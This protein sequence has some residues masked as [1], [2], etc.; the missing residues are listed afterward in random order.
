[1]VDDSPVVRLQLSRL[2]RRD[3]QIQIVGKALD[4]FAARDEIFQLRPDVVLLDIGLPR[5]D[6][7]TFLKAIM[8]HQPMPVIIVSGLVKP[9]SERAIAALEAGAFDVVYKTDSDE[10]L[11]GIGQELLGKIHQ[12]AKFSTAR[13]PAAIVHTTAPRKARAE[14]TLETPRL[15]APV[16][17]LPDIAT[18]FHP[19]Q[20]LLLGASTGGTEALKRILTRLP[21]EMP[22]IAIVQHIPPKFSKSFADRLNTICAL[23]VREAVDGDQLTPGLALIAPGGY[24]MEIFWRGRNYEVRLNQRPEV[25]HQRPAVDLLFN[26]AAQCAGPHAVA[27]LLTGMGRDGAE[28]LKRLRDAG[29]QTVAQD[30]ASC[31]VFGMPMA[32][33]QLGAAE[34][35]ISLDAMPQALLRRLERPPAKVAAA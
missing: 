22:P 7:I 13:G 8:E 35:M 23:E 16:R 21:S 12:A 26:S 14:P 25:H 24:H 9:G 6:G 34:Q 19:R 15:A 30:E 11:A 1:M 5:L 31:V 32:A 17:R 4:V 2:L 27:A 3:P 20:I 28:G 10:T 18:G 33:M 29:A